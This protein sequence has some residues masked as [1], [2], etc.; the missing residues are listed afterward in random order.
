MALLHRHII[1]VIEET[2]QPDAVSAVRVK[3]RAL[4]QR[5]FGS[6]QEHPPFNLNAMASFCGLHESAEPPRF[7]ADS[8][9]APESDG[10]IV[11][12][13]NRDRPKTRQRFSIG[14]E[15][16]HTF[17]PEYR[18]RLQCRKP[19]N[20]DWADPND[21]LETLCDVAASELLFPEPWF[22]DRV[23]KLNLCAEEIVTLASEYQASRDA[24]VRRLVEVHESP[25]AALF[26]SW[27]LKPTEVR[28]QANDKNQY[29]M[30]DDDELSRQRPKL[31]VDYAVA[32]GTFAAMHVAHVPSDK[33]IPSEGVIY[34][35]S[36][37]QE[38]RDGAMWLDLGTCAGNFMVHAIPVYTPEHM[39][40]PD[41]RVS[42]AAI[43]R[44][45]PSSAPSAA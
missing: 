16:G 23:S 38:S 36:G 17:F 43:I 34:E 24:T 22:S 32:N 41:R 11:L 18:Y 19:L 8:E 4:V 21:L 6:F 3:A 39:L 7:S 2:G 33:S 12:R 42:I 30:F 15:I 44:P 25:L 45:M 28:Q 20:R 26:L 10:R 9:I 1:A 31:R 40:G 37:T 29:K 13:V 35:A 27:K 14:H 5:Y